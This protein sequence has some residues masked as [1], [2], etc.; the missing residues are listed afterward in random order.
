M[1]AADCRIRT[2]PV[3]SRKGFSLRA[4]S[5]VSSLCTK[6][7]LSPTP[8]L[9]RPARA[10]TAPTPCAWPLPPWI[11]RQFCTRSQTWVLLI[12]AKN[13]SSAVRG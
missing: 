13:G 5:P 12:P 4:R 2:S 11:R 9:G 7:V 8:L 10:S 3:W 1:W 6:V